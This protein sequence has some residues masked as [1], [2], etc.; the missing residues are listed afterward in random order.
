MHRSARRPL[1]LLI[2]G[3]ALLA[4]CTTTEGTSPPDTT[5]DGR[6]P[7]RADLAFALTR[8]DE[9]E[10]FEERV[11][12]VAAET[13]GPW[14]LGT[15]GVERF[16]AV[17]RAVA[18]DSAAM[19]SSGAP[20][21][22][23]P[24]A[25]TGGDEA[26]AS[27]G[28]ATDGAWSGT[29]VQEQGVDEPDLVKTDGDVVL[30]LVDGQLRAVR[31]VDG[32][33]Q[34]VGS[35]ALESFGGD[36]LLADGNT[37]LLLS[38]SYGMGQETLGGVTTREMDATWYAGAARLRTV[39]VSDPAA[40]AITGE[41]SLEGSLVSARMIDGVVRVVTTS[42]A[43]DLPLVQPAG[44]GPRAQEAAERLNR[45]AIEETDADDWLPRFAVADA[46]GDIVEEGALVGCD[47]VHAA[48]ATSTTSPGLGMVNVVSVDLR[49]GTLAPSDA[50]SVMGSG[51]TIYASPA[52]LY[53]ASTSWSDETSTESTQVHKFDTGGRESVAYVSSGQVEGHLLNQFAMSEHNGDLRVAT[54]RTNLS[55][56]GFTPFSEEGAGDAA[57]PE[58]TVPE[59][60]PPTET[61]VVEP[62]PS[63]TVASVPTTSTTST[64]ATTSPEPTTTIV[65]PEPLPAPLPPIGAPG[66]DSVVWVLRDEGGELRQIGAVGGLGQGEQIQSVRFLGDVGYVV[67]FRQ[68]DPLYTIDLSD[69]ANPR[70]MGELKIPGFSSYLHP[71]GD[72]LL[73]GIGRDADLSGR[74]T[75]MQLTVFDVSDLSNPVELQRVSLPNASSEAEWDHHAFLW[76]PETSTAVVPVQEF[77]PTGVFTG[78]VGYRVGA[79]GIGELGRVIHPEDP[80]FVDDYCPPGAA[81]AP[82]IELSFG[83]TPITRSLV[84]DGRL[85]TVSSA[86][87]ETSDLNSL[88]E[89]GWAAF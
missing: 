19:E 83:G 77:A 84:V 2:G 51:H 42:G 62:G 81:C 69:P 34:L 25:F 68:I 14:G 67:T 65:T 46:D 29:N 82:P 59:E 30:S 45:Q 75:G 52:N 61:T 63:T 87:L 10:A 27:A 9:C 55:T 31:I 41:V 37:V 60:D 16:S 21:T 86:G 74:T 76:S 6:S 26:T 8:F 58:T 22:T 13:V 48:K 70:V 85:V 53:V 89:I 23:T 33:P 47:G 36:Q 71:I 88:A 39:D 78:A 43:P 79:A 5:P 18:D 28:A 57:T 32:Q 20:S 4:S 80:T 15:G 54:T 38:N 66:T 11:Q 7:A 64:T 73:L 49:A 24:L 35:L 44:D 72:G 1:A 3:L 50:V 56:D 40:M 17:G 12:A